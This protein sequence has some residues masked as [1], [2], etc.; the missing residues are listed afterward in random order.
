MPRRDRDKKKSFL[1]HT[2]ARVP[3]ARA[4]GQAKKSPAQIEMP[5]VACRLY[6]NE[7]AALDEIAAAQG[8]SRNAL[9]QEIVREYL[10]CKQ[11]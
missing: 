7:R 2:S 8:I 5:T 3:T 10:S 11:G 6:I 4:N 9:L 1:G